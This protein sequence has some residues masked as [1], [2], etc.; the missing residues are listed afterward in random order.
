MLLV[1]FSYAL[2]AESKLTK[3]KLGV[4]KCGMFPY[5]LVATSL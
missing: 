5:I 3:V 4:T 1:F 2:V